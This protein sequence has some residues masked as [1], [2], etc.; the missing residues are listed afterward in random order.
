ML[1]N[2]KLTITRLNKEEHQLANE[3]IPNALIKRDGLLNFY[4]VVHDLDP[5]YKGGYYF[6]LL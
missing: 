1:G 3:P 2:K 5:P 4:F 6:G